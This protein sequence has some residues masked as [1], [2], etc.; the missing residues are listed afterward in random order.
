M[1]NDTHRVGYCLKVPVSFQ[2]VPYRTISF[3]KGDLNDTT[4]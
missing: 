1:Y 4:V 3:L 2:E